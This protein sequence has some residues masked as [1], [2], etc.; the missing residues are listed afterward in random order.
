MSTKFRVS[1]EIPTMKVREQVRKT[2]N[3]TPL[4]AQ[5]FEELA[6]EARNNQ[7]I[8]LHLCLDPDR[9]YEEK[10]IVIAKVKAALEEIARG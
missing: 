5:I 1:S 2:A 7:G 3:F 6:T 9:Y 8:I 4:Q 10:K